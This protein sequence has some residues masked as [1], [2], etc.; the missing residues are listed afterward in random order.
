MR[1]LFVS[2]LFHPHIGG[3]ERHVLG[4]AREASKGNEVVVLTASHEGNLPARETLGALTILRLPFSQG[5]YFSKLFAHWAFLSKNRALISRF[6]VIH[7]NDVPT[8]L[9]LLPFPGK[10]VITFHG[11]ERDPPRFYHKLLRKFA[12]RGVLENFCVGRYLTKTYGT[13]CKEENLIVGGLDPAEYQ[14]G[15]VRKFAKR[16][17]FIGRLEPD[18]HIL[19]YLRA[20]KLLP[21]LSL[22]IYG[23][24][25]LERL[26]RAFCKKEGIPARFQGVTKT[27]GKILP[28]Y[29]FAF[30]S[31]QLSILESL[32]SGCVVFALWSS[33]MQQEM[34]SGIGA[35]GSSLR[36][37]PVGLAR[38][39][40]REVGKYG[41]NRRLFKK[42]VSKGKSFALSF[43]WKKVFEKY[44]RTYSELAR[45][46]LSR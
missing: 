16:A 25:S 28:K 43:G 13:V 8:F 44:S 24:G 10:K 39:I 35:P 19:E 32:A 46:S 38:E 5:G 34:L 20:M 21:A 23:A 6:D 40:A 11:F 41:K 31:K 12:E 2:P 33:N 17:V 37:F 15:S 29:K 22:D 4:V 27:P 3:V 14:R 45:S 26:A 1:I 30:A 18:A 9:W 42:A 7:L 36:V